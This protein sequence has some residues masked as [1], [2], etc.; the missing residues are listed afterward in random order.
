MPAGK[1][2]VEKVKEEQAMED[3]ERFAA[4]TNMYV[5][6]EKTDRQ[7]YLRMRRIPRLI[8]FLAG[9]AL[10]AYLIYN[11]V[12]LIRWSRL[13]GTSIF[14]ETSAWIGFT[15]IA[16]YIVLI[17]RE[18]LA[19]RLYAKRER[20]RLVEKYGTDRIE[21]R[22]DFLEDAIEIH[23]LASDAKLRL[24]YDSFRF[25]TETKDLFL[26]RTEQK[27]LIGLDK[28]GFSGIDAAG[29]CTFMDQKC[30]GARRAWK[31]ENTK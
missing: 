31:K 23:N 22:S 16:L 6:C 26:L 13:A 20:K 8:I 9:T 11:M 25:L 18:I 7:T 2:K 1:G 17:V 3:Q 27:Q 21:I 12:E 14:S 24:S 19:P 10:L 5:P 29:F 30:K 28:C 15:A 4:F